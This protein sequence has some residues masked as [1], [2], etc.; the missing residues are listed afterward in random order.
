MF[1]VQS[2]SC[3]L[4]MSTLN[5]KAD[6]YGGRRRVVSSGGNPR[7]GRGTS[8]VEDF[9][10]E[11]RGS[12][13]SDRSDPDRRLSVEDFDVSDRLS[14]PSVEEFDVEVFNV[15][16]VEESK[17]RVP[18]KVNFKTEDS[19]RVSVEGFG[20]ERTLGKKYLDSTRV[21]SWSS[22]S[23]NQRPN[24]NFPNRPREKTETPRRTRGNP[25]SKPD[26][27]PE[28]IM[29]FPCQNEKLRCKHIPGDEE[30]PYH[31]KWIS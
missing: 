3:V 24:F 18:S 13:S 17:P 23:F 5:S 14:R 31:C 4:L 21:S 1:S 10:R 12:G 26:L 6:A 8:S 20:T 29:I 19:R 27:L 25:V 28:R 2:I 15:R 9:D 22:W 16:D 7:G 11:D 30:T